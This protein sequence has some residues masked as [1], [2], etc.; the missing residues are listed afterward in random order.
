MRV[1]LTGM[2]VLAAA[3]ASGLCGG[4]ASAPAVS[5]R[6]SDAEIRSVLQ[7]KVPAQATP[8]EVSRALD[9]L[10]V[11]GRHRMNYP[12]ADSRPHVLLARLFEPGG[13]WLHGDDD[14]VEWVDVSFVFS[15]PPERLE[16]T[17]VFRD[18]LRYFQREPIVYPHAPKRALMSRP[19]RFPAPIPPPADPLETPQ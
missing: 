5:A 13:F 8:D 2:L 14:D 18:K 7:E 9:Q 3:V 1:P 4:C 11:S 15:A 17:I 12:A 16:R 6:N 19:G 10:G